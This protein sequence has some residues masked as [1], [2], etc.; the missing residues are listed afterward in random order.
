MVINLITNKTQTLPSARK[1][2]RWKVFAQATFQRPVG[3]G[4]VAFA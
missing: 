2:A 1:L 4:I 3:L